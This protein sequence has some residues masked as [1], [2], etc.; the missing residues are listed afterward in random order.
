MRQHGADPKHF[1]YKYILSSYLLSYQATHY[2]ATYLSAKKR[3][4]LKLAT[5]PAKTT[6]RNIDTLT[7]NIATYLYAQQRW[8]LN[9]AMLLAK[10][11]QRSKNLLIVNIAQFVCNMKLNSSSLFQFFQEIIDN[12]GRRTEHTQPGEPTDQGN[13][14]DQ[15]RKG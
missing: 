9:L 1:R 6:Q 11:N 15:A 5:L 12:P 3:R 10:T 13:W 14:I 8:S 2:L 7:V 4:S